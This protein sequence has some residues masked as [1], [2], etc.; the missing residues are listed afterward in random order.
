MDIGLVLSDG[1]SKLDRIYSILQCLTL[2]KL[3][4]KRGE[5][6]QASRAICHLSVL[7]VT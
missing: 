3:N 7:I 2:S 5:L 6:V 1:V 4:P